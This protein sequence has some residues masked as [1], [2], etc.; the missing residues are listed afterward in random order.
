MRPEM[1]RSAEL[2]RRHTSLSVMHS[3]VNRI[4]HYRP[5]ILSKF[6]FYGVRTTGSKEIPATPLSARAEAGNVKLVREWATTR[7]II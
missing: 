1:Y 6:A 2:I 5:H 3:G 4:D 7:T